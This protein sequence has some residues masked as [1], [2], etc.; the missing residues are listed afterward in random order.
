MAKPSYPKTNEEKAKLYLH[1]MA[2]VKERLKVIQ[3]ALALPLEPLF[4]N[5]ICYLQFRHICEVVAI[6][7]LAAQGDFETQRAFTEEYSVAKIF[8]ALRKF[9]P[10]FFPECA[11]RMSTPGSHHI[12][13]NHKADAY[14]EKAV[15]DLWNISG[16]HLHRASVNKYLKATFAKPPTLDSVFAHFTGLVRLLETHL[17]PIQRDPARDVRLLVELEDGQGG[18][19]ARFLTLDHEKL[20]IRVEEFRV[21]YLG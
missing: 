1:C 11:E 18:I 12:E 19:T 14:G 21:A 15:L 17:I 4:V 8:N 16:D 9:Y 10:D 7:C 13:R 3:A 20:E 6:G 2:E 5:E